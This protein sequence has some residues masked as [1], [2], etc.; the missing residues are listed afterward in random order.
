VIESMLALFI[1]TGMGFFVFLF[2]LDR[3]ARRAASQPG[4]TSPAEP[5]TLPDGPN[6]Q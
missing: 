2:V 3:R 5:T 6:G 1:L 4:T